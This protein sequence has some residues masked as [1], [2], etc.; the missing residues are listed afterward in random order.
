MI[1]NNNNTININILNN[2]IINSTR[3]QVISIIIM[4]L[5]KSD[6][7]VRVVD[8]D[9]FIVDDGVFIGVD[10]VLVVVI[11]NNAVYIVHIATFVSIADERDRVCCIVI[12]SV[13]SLVLMMSLLWYTCLRCL[14][15]GLQ[16]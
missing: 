10:D 3:V 14:S 13:M 11:N 5:Y 1:V 6:V 15:C 2:C 9:M 16:Y 4:T 12:L 8:V 7:N